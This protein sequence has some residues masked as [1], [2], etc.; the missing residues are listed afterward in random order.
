MHNP[1]SK[2]TGL[3]DRSISFLFLLPHS[4]E[5][6]PCS[7]SE[8]G[9]EHLEVCEDVWAVTNALGAILPAFIGHWLGL[10]DAKHTPIPRTL[11]NKELS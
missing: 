11:Q 7:G 9:V 1:S 10:K 4:F 5:V 6:I 3:R 2:E 8:S